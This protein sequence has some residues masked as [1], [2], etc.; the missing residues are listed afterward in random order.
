MVSVI[1]WGFLIEE[2]GLT[3]GMAILVYLTCGNRRVTRPKGEGEGKRDEKGVSDYRFLSPLFLLFFL[4]NQMFSDEEVSESR[5]SSNSRERGDDQR[6]KEGME[7][8]RGDNPLED[9][10]KRCNHYHR[11]IKLEQSGKTGI[12]SR[13][14]LGKWK[15]ICAESHYDY[16]ILRGGFLS[17]STLITTIAHRKQRL[18]SSF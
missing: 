4:S 7:G 11:G 15:R 17:I 10:T 1:R 5:T 8:V 12:S 18:Y 14:I 9:N 16:C 3:M 13:N 2:R 6:R